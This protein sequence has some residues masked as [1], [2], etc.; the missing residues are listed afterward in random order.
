MLDRTQCHAIMRRTKSRPPRICA[1]STFPRAP[2]PFLSPHLSVASHQQHRFDSASVL[3]GFHD[4]AAR[5]YVQRSGAM[6]KASKRNYRACEL[7]EFRNCQIE[8][9]GFLVFNLLFSSWAVSISLV[10]QS[11]NAYSITLYS[12]ILPLY[13]IVVENNSTF[14]TTKKFLS[15]LQCIERSVSC[16]NIDVSHEVLVLAQGRGLV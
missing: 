12:S 9:C 15:P 13:L 7:T 3:H 6:L 10:C 5:W 2:T 8:N 1:T 16:V 14:V 4:R 11:I